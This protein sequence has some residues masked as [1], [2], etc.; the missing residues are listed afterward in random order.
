M[1]PVSV[2]IPARNEADNIARLLESLYAQPAPPA[3]VIV[4]DAG[5]TDETA[6]IA[7]KAGA[8]VIQVDR[9]YPGQA[10]DIGI[11]HARQER[12]AC[13][14]ASM[15]AAPG[16]L[17]ALVEPLLRGEADLV[18]GHLE[19]RP[20]TRASWL[21]FLVLTPPY[22]HILEG[23]QVL[24]APPVACTTFRKSLW[25]AVGGFRPWRAREDSDFRK[26]VEHAGARVV[27][28]PEAI[29]YWEPAESWASLL[30]KVR[31]YG[32]HNLL[33]GKPWEWYRGLLRFYGVLLLLVGVAGIWVGPGAFG[34]LLISALSVGIAA[35]TLRKILRY[36][37]F[38]QKRG[39]RPYTLRVFFEGMALLF[40]TDIASFLGLGDWVVLDKLRLSPETFPAPKRVAL[41]SAQP[42]N[43]A[44]RC[45]P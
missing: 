1:L 23:G 21:S 44:E 25:Q 26:R 16:C 4:V 40:L 2:V 9:A 24:Y 36:G 43:F 17:S 3:E 13:W 42:P 35:R 12:I 31:L 39:Y 20:R 45:D 32:R 8:T 37:P 7:H 11:A 6:L 28:R 5:S 33:S 27:F 19:V 10:R 15:W 18:Q 14:D 38:W 29:T 34:L 22:T 41:F 30:R